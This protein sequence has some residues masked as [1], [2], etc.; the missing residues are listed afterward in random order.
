MVQ[1]VKASRP[2]VR[3]YLAGTSDARTFC[4]ANAPPFCVERM[5]YVGH[6][7]TGFT[8]RKATLEL[9]A[10]CGTYVVMGNPV[11]DRGPLLEVAVHIC[12]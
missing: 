6:S 10:L 8:V 5:E 7:S 1:S 11:W 2:N 12:G 4:V 9:T 3:K